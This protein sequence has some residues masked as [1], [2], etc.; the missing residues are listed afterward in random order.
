VLELL[1]AFDAKGLVVNLNWS[2]IVIKMLF[3]SQTWLW[4]LAAS[5]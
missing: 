2:R 4:M 1:T 3:Y 5:I